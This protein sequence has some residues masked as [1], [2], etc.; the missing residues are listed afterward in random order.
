M[1]RPLLYRQLGELIVAQTILEKHSLLHMPL[2]E[3]I[4]AGIEK[5]KEEY[6]AQVRESLTSQDANTEKRERSTDI[7]V[8]EFH[9][10]KAKLRRAVGES[11]L[12]QEQ[13][14]I[15]MGYP[16]NSARSAISNMLSSNRSLDLRLS[17]LLGLAKALGRPLSELIA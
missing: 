14:G 16:K 11:G 5:L 8:D 1:N 10:V 13:I 2:K 17:T 6:T 4:D 12:T 3:A 7:G 9:T 15:L